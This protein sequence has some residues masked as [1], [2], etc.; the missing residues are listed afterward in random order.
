MRLS[1]ERNYIKRVIRTWFRQDQTLLN[2]SLSQGID[3]VVR[4]NRRFGRKEYAQAHTEWQ[5]VMRKLQSRIPRN[6]KTSLDNAVQPPNI[7]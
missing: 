4:A 6:E 2:A 7:A 1:V 5:S 3:L